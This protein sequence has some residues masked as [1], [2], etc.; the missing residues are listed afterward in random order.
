MP[1]SRVTR[2]SSFVVERGGTREPM[3]NVLL[4]CLLIGSAP[5]QESV[6][7]IP[8]G[9]R[10]Y[11]LPTSSFEIEMVSALHT[12]NVP[13]VVVSS[14]NAADFEIEAESQSDDGQRVRQ[15]AIVTVKN[16]HTSAII[17]AK[18]IT[19]WASL[20]GNKSVA[21]ACAN[22]LKRNI[23]PLSA[24]ELAAFQASPRFSDAASVSAASAS[25]APV[26]SGPSSQS[27]AVSGSTVIDPASQGPSL[28]EIAREARGGK[29]QKIEVQEIERSQSDFSPVVDTRTAPASEPSK[30]EKLLSVA[31]RHPW[32]TALGVFAALWL[33]KSPNIS[34]RIPLDRFLTKKKTAK[35]AAATDA[36]DHNWSRTKQFYASTQPRSQVDP[37]LFAILGVQPGCTAEQLRAAYVRLMKQWHTDRLEGMAPELKEF[38]NREICRINEA[39][40]KLSQ[41]SGQS[42]L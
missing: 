6:N 25:P 18:K 27:P 36:T 22:D 23:V 10:V 29:R 34:I 31:S 26:T 12:K 2:H 33:W 21:E 39:Y 16:L 5:A 30:I 13:V 35:S 41:Q 42:V 40:A 1:R 38:A 20:R 4:L 32:L 37:E 14:R 17:Y 9:S 24:E 8:E 19:K 3:H 28:G 7:N 15:T 11:V